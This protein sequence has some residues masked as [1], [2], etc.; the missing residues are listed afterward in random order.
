MPKI[1]FKNLIELFLET[2]IYQIKS[3]EEVP[4]INFKFGKDG[5]DLFEK[6]I[7]TSSCY[8]KNN[9][10]YLINH[11]NDDCIT[12]KI[13]DSVKF[14]K[15]LT[16]IANE[17][18]KLFYDYDD[19]VDLNET[20]MYLLRR[21]W[22]RLGISDIENI[23]FFLDKQLQFVKN[24]TFD[25]YKL[26]KVGTFFEHSVFMKT[27]ANELWDETTRSMV[28]TI[29]SDEKVYELPHILYDIDDQNI[30]YIY[31]VQNCQFSKDRTIERKL[32]KLNNG[33]ENPNVH[34]SKV[35]SLL[36]FIEQLKKR[37]IHEIVVPSMQVLSYRYHELLSE[38]SKK[39]YDEIKNE[40]EKYPNDDFIKGRYKYIG[41]WYKHVYEKYDKI[42][43]LKTEE[44][45]YLI[46]RI[47]EHSKDVKILNEVNL[48]GDYVKIRILN[49][50][51]R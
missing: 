51:R 31:G 27:K 18:I 47:T 20:V 25:N 21:I 3:E 7:S 40:Y 24:R 29:G 50:G 12:I 16:E 45:I 34:P 46:Y 28:F 19:I 41:D 32:Y 35:L 44:L 38:A 49:H 36:L 4:N 13:N 23:E 8:N 14:F 10:N 9:L 6:V 48:E 39:N 1:E 15:Y 43:Y 5:L 17:T 22:L 30:C 42:S 11:C 33:I 2:S 26:E 37:G